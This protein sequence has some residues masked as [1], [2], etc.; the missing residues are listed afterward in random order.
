MISNTV[1]HRDRKE[2]IFPVRNRVQNK[3]DGTVALIMALSRAMVLSPA[4]A[5]TIEVW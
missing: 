3:I 5:G 4:T 2:N 1:C